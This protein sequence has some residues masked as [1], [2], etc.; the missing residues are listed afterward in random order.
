MAEKIRRFKEL[1][2]WQEGISLV[3]EVYRITK[4]FPS[5]ELYGLSVQMRRAAVSVPSNVAEGFRRK[6]KK[7]FRQFLNIALGSLA[8]LETQVVIAKELDYMNQIEEDK[9]SKQIDYISR[10]I[11]TL[12]NKL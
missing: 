7:E 10:M 5:E 4:T 1:R 9:F 6:F 2:I 12:I 11:T 3:K 8:E